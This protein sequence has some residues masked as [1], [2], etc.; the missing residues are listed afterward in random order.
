MPFHDCALELFQQAWRACEDADALI[1]SPLAVMAAALIAQARD[2]PLAVAEA[3]PSVTSRLLPHASFP[4]LPLGSWYNRLTHALAGR[5]FLRGA[6]PVFQVWLAEARRLRPSA[7]SRPVRSVTLAAV[8]PS[9][10]PRPEDWPASA[11]VTGYWFLPSRDRT[12][13][14]AGLR[15]FVEQGPPPICLGFGSMADDNPQ[16]LKRIVVNALDR[17]NLRAVVVAGSGGALF[18]FDGHD[19]ILEVPFADYDW[20][21]PTS[22]RRGA[23]RRRRHRV[24]LP[25]RRRAADDRAL[26]SGSHVLELADAGD[27]RG[28]GEHPAAQAHEPR[29]GRRDP[30]RRR[31]S[32]LSSQS[33]V[34]CAGDTR[35]G[36][37]DAC[38]RDPRAALRGRLVRGTLRW[39]V[40][41]TVS[42]AA[43]QPPRDALTD[44]Q[45]VGDD[46]EAGIDSTARGKEGA[47]HHVDVVEVVRPVVTVEHAR[48]GIVAETAGP[49][50]VAVVQR[51]MGP[52]G[53]TENR[54]RTARLKP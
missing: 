33:R 50:D 29:A 16:E 5:L 19:N 39:H 42:F 1:C 46:R 23:P 4:A 12:T 52:S 17:L 21:F 9:V 32:S 24:I 54:W 2:L 18:G 53:C 31:K 7:A 6:A 8:S 22:S 10:V 28:I 3:V 38:L 26:L 47:V 25:H 40:I 44:A 30:E 27:R 35:R 43:S 37:T 20:L 13:I 48:R 45:A 41:R 11:Y 51:P 15:A 14:P 34:A 36:R 49:A